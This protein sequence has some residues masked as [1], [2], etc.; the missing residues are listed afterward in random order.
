MRQGNERVVAQLRYELNTVF[1][2]DLHP[3]ESDP[4]KQEDGR[5][6]LQDC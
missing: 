3:C 2:P 4:C 5:D 1:E 6:D